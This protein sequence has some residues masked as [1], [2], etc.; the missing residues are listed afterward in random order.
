MSQLVRATDE[1]MLSSFPTGYL[2]LAIESA[3]HGNL[4][5][6]L[7]KSR[8][9]E[10]DPAFAIA[11][12]TASK[13]SSQQL[14]HF[15]ADMARGMD[16]LSQKQ[17]IHRDLAARNI[18]VG[19]NYIA[20]IADFGLSQGQEVYVKRTM[21]R[22]PVRWMVIESLNYSVYTTNSDVGIF[23]AHGP[24]D[25]QWRSPTGRQCDFCGRRSGFVV[26]SARQLFV[27]RGTPYCG[28]TCAELYEKLPQGY[29]L[30]KPLNC[31]D[32]V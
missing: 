4:L 22:L 12:S 26:A 7:R 28:M 10:T 31:D 18:L 24:E 27:H 29:R 8:V 14:L 16:Y 30:E 2:Y 6:F 5:D 32:E 1:S 25:F 13:L 17:F 11:N 21:G 19:E 15:T 3:P 20:K 9:L 23:I